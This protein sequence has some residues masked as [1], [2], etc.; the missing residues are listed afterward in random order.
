MIGDAKRMLKRWR[1]PG[2]VL[3]KELDV[4]GRPS[5]VNYWLAFNGQ[6]YKVAKNHLRSATKEERLADRVFNRHIKDIRAEM[7]SDKAQLQF[8]DL[9]RQDEDLRETRGSIAVD[10]L[11]APMERPVAGDRAEP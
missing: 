7:Q 5:K 6:L 4:H 11:Q 1:G 8:T 9:T 10:L 3:G 2:I